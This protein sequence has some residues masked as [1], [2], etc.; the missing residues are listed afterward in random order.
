MLRSLLF[1]VKFLLKGGFIN[2]RSRLHYSPT[3][4][5]GKSVSVFF[6]QPSLPSQLIFL[7]EE[8]RVGHFSDLTVGPGNCILIKD[9]TTL[10]THCKIAGDVTIERYCLLSANILISSGAHYINVAPH[11]LVRQQDNLVLNDPIKG[12]THSKPVHIEE[13]VW[14][15][16]NVFVK[17]GITIGRGAVIGAN[18]T[19]I[20]DVAPYDIVAGSPAKKIKSRLQFIPPKTISAV[21]EFH[22]PYF[23]RGF[24][25]LYSPGGRM[26]VIDPLFIV[27][28]AN[29]SSGDKIVM[30]GVS[31]HKNRLKVSVTIEGF[32][33]ASFD[34][35]AESNFVVSLEPEQINFNKTVNK[36]Y[37][38]LI[39][40]AHCENPQFGL[41][42][43]ELE[44]K[45]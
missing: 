45:V 32:R 17:Q 15:G 35:A 44:S 29:V 1:F 5:L 30:K 38:F 34:V 21:D 13:D 25:H 33:D 24:D 3:S 16:F 27:A 40:A 8:V 43:V 9:Y 37:T 7:G 4:W 31:A 22:R 26:N 19:V 18:S 10:N 41:F 23:Y 6:E 42:S 12:K 36:S 28:L 14:I 20:S 39:F 2:D 11:L